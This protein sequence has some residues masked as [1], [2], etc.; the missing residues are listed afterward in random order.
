MC[1]CYYTVFIVLGV[2]VLTFCIG[3]GTYYTYKYIIR[4]K[5]NVSV[6]DYTYQAKN[7]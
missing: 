5:E 1:A 6:Y 3:I 7:Y 2:I 4:N